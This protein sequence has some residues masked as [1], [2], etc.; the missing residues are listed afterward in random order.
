MLTILKDKPG[1]NMNKKD[2]AAMT[3]EPDEFIPGIYHSYQDSRVRPANDIKETTRS[4]RKFDL[5]AG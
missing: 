5:S 3:N 4:F 2:T 1:W